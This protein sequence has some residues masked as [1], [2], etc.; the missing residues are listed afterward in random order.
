MSY[1]TPIGA[2]AQIYFDPL[3]D[4]RGDAARAGDRDRDDRA[5]LDRDDGAGRWAGRLDQM[6]DARERFDRFEQFADGANGRWGG[7][8]RERDG[9]DGDWGGGFRRD[10]DDRLRDRDGDDRVRDRDDRFGG[11]ELRRPEGEPFGQP[12]PRL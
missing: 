2:Q 10:G 1:L 8:D 3:D 11:D 12:Q 5:A 9:R 6:E 4:E 7:I